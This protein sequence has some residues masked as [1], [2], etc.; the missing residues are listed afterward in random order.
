MTVSEEQIHDSTSRRPSSQSTTDG[1]PRELSES[2]QANHLVWLGTIVSC[3]LPLE[4]SHANP[5]L[6]YSV[7]RA[8][9]EGRRKGED[10]NNTTWCSCVSRNHP[11]SWPTWFTLGFFPPLT[12]HQ[13]MLQP[14]VRK[15]FLWSWTHVHT[16]DIV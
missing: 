1:N 3:L 11:A 5:F 9:K 4:A 10:N 13:P 16:F 12:S 15:N 6:M 7:L 14:W 8:M 2:W